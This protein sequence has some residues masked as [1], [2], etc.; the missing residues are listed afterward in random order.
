M[1]P[2]LVAAVVAQWVL[3]VAL[4]IVL[5][6]LLRQ[7]G[8][9]HERLGPVGALSLSGGPKVGDAAPRFTLTAI[10]GRAVEIGGASP[11]STL[12]FFLS[13]SCPICK[14]LIPVIKSIVREQ[15]SELR[16]ILASDGDLEAQ[17]RMVTKHALGAFPLVLSTELGLAYEVSK[18]PHAVL[19][20]AAGRVAA[21]GLVNN[22]EHLES[23]FE[24]RDQGVA[25]LQEYRKRKVLAFGA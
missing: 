6:A 12:L 25:T 13:P 15:G 11:A 19:L 2:A 7:V 9:L 20:D 24:A 14:S 22:R 8:M 21:K 3:L 1:I 4:G 16:L 10:D 5:L 23:L 18:L 17:H